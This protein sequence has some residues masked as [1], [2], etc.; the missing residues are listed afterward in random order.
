MK[1][2]SCRHEIEA[3]YAARGGLWSA[4]LERHV[5]DCDVCR[6]TVL[7]SGAVAS[8]APPAAMLPDPELIR[9]KAQLIARREAEV[10][11]SRHFAMYQIAPHAFAWA[12][13][14]GWLIWNRSAAASLLD[15]IL[16]KLS[17]S[18][19]LLA[20][21]SLFPRVESFDPLTLSAVL[22]G[23]AVFTALVALE[24]LSASE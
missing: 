2:R 18:D 20:G 7:V 16:S 19:A 14:G 3:A 9:L 1:R 23:L 8:L 6:E 11:K 13:G 4:D 12:A 17:L 15:G 22:I 10:K 24:P 21:G 5:A